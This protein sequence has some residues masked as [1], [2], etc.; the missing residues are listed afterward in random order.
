MTKPKRSTES[1]KCV[2]HA[3][4]VSSPKMTV[5]IPDI[6]IPTHDPV[7]LEWALRLIRELDPGRVILLGDVLDLDALSRFQKTR[8]REAGLIDEL[9]EVR[10]W[11]GYV[12]RQWRKREVTYLYGNHEVRLE[13]YLLRNAPELAELP[14]LSLRALLCV[15]DRWTT[16]PYKHH[17]I[18]QGVLV[19]HGVRFAHGLCQSNLNRLGMSSVC[20]HSHRAAMA[21][22]SRPDGSVITAVESG[23]LSKLSACYAPLT[24][25]VQ[26][27]TIIDDGRVEL[28]R[29]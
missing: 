23:C 2:S 9:D 17:V 21:H 26:A 13:S 16:V 24:D 20:G 27:C 5:C 15:P 25:W 22:R 10:E 11:I 12:E 4:R 3:K 7:A 1:K 8:R 6:H 29:R 19:E 14:E 18:E 28:V